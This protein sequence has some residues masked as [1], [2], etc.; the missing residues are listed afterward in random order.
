MALVKRVGAP[1]TITT[2][3]TNDTITLTTTSAQGVI[4]NGNLTILGNTTALETQNTTLKDNII[5]LNDGET[6]AGV[7]A[8]GGVSGIAVDR[9]S[10]ANVAL[11][12]Y[13]PFLKWQITTDGTTYANLLTPGPGTI[14]SVSADPAPSLGGNLNTYS[15]QIWSNVANINFNGNLQLT[16]QGT[17]PA[18]SSGN[19][20]IYASTVGGGVTGIYVVNSQAA[21]QELITKTRSL[22][23]SILL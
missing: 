10:L 15:Y 1:Y 9:G 12:W 16:N 20:I 19:A 3:N 11:R 2:T 13:E 8:G 5:M 7:T 21:G 18:Q 23:L 4:I 6:G 17:V 22:G 14:G